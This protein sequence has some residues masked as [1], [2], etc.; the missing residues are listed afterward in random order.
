VL[1]GGMRQAGYLAAACIYA[2]ENNVERLAEDHNHAQLLAECLSK[3]DFTGEILPVE[4]N[5]L[6]F[7]V[8]G[9]LSPQEFSAKLKEDDIHVMAISKTHVRMVL[10]LDV[11]PEMVQQTIK[12]INEI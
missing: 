12:V 5:I 1:G 9:R 10:H 6:I 11:S 2:F 8:K 4:T 3:K 7:E